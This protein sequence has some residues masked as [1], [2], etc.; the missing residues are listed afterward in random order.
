MASGLKILV[1]LVR[2]RPWAQRKRQKNKGDGVA[3][4]ASVAF[5]SSTESTLTG[6]KPVHAPRR[7]LLVAGGGPQPT[8]TREW[9]SP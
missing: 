9:V 5:G 1:S 6:T 2:F 4:D 8:Q 7:V 3:D